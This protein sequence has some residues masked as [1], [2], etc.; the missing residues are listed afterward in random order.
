[1]PANIILNDNGRKRPTVQNT[2]ALFSY[3]A[4]K[5][6]C[7]REGLLLPISQKLEMPVL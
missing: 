4:S 1:M 6:K 7:L 3:K 5:V 2:P